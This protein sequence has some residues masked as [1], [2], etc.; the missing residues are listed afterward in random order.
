MNS[1]GPKT[2]PSQPENGEN[3]AARARGGQFAP[4]SPTV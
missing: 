3:A 1:T 2:G 4:R